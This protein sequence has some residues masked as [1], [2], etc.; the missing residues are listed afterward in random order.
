MEQYLHV[1]KKSP[2]FYG[3]REEE[4][5]TMLQCMAADQRQY[6]EG[7]FICRMGEAATDFAMVL[8]G[9]RNRT[10]YQDALPVDRFHGAHRDLS[11]LAQGKSGPTA[12][13]CENPRDGQAA[14]QASPIGPAER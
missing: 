5:P 8:D 4:I 9:R 11:A 1:I 3:L 12:R 14:M 2:L 7:E 13:C 6:Q 10:E